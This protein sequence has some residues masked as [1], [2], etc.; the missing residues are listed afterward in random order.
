[1]KNHPPQLLLSYF[2]TLS[3]TRQ[4]YRWKT[5]EDRQPKQL[6]I[7]GRGVIKGFVYVFSLLWSAFM[8]LCF[9]FSFLSSNN[10]ELTT[11]FFKPLAQLLVDSGRTES[12][13]GEEQTKWWKWYESCW[14]CEYFP[15]PSEM[16]E[17]CLSHQTS[18][19]KKAYIPKGSIQFAKSNCKKWT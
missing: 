12:K 10:R 11:H 5:K 4:N 9:H 1:M 18:L 7:K 13:W 8:T 2:W 19:K 3:E 14:I 16:S 15:Q 17:S 6:W